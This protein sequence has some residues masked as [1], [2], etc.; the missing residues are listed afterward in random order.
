M[1]IFR[2]FQD[3]GRP[4]SLI[5]DQCVWTTHEGH[6]MVFIIVQNLVGIDAVVLIICMFFDLTS[7]AGKR[8]FTNQKLGF[9]GI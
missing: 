9:S 4:P 8:L 3:G 6:M 7:L 1:A 5:C 2:C